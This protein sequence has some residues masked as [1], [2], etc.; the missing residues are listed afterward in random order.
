M[1]HAIQWIIRRLTTLG[2]GS[3]VVG[4]AVAE[5]ESEVGNGMM[6]G[7]VVGS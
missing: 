7:R 4:V 6:T 3:G 1:D 5:A 2:E